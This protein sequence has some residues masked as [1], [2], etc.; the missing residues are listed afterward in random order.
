MMGAS[1]MFPLPIEYNLSGSAL[2]HV[3]ISQGGVDISLH[4]T[5]RYVLVSAGSFLP[6]VA[7]LL[8]VRH[9]G[10]FHEIY[11]CLRGAFQ[12]FCSTANQTLKAQTFMHLPTER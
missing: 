12:L 9:R 7:Q 11:I 5:Q 6:V 2:V 8:V 10:V 1:V 4:V 3:N